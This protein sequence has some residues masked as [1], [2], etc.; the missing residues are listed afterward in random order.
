[1]G[2][3]FCNRQVKGIRV[4]DLRFS[5]YIFF[6]IWDAGKIFLFIIWHMD[7]FLCFT[8]D[9]EENRGEK[10]TSE[11]QCKNLPWS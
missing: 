7:F 2:N 9:Q 3:V 10:P 1:M 11:K 6:S 8:I 5:I 4:S